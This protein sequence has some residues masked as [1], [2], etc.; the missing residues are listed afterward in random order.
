MSCAKCQADG[1]GGL[2][3]QLCYFCVNLHYILHDGRQGNGPTLLDRHSSD[4]P[5]ESDLKRQRHPTE[6]VLQRDDSV[7]C[8][9]KKF[10]MMPFVMIHY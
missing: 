1:M 5:T 4:R 3:A 2:C 7:P 6:K 10:S 9:S 8:L